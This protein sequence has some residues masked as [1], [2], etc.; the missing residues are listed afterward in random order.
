[1]SIDTIAFIIGG[2]LI[3]VG[4]LGGGIQIKDLTVPPVAK[5]VR[6][7][8]C[9]VGVAFVCIALFIRPRP[10]SP[11]VREPNRQTQTFGEPAYGG[12]RLDACYEWGQRCGQDAATAWCKT[13]GFTR[14]IDFQTETVGDRHIVTKLIGTQVECREPFC[15]SFVYITCER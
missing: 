12:A 9:V 10:S 3:V 11:E 8:C 6:I 13:Q 2:G 15:A 1:M 7:L 5:T 14:A 4:V